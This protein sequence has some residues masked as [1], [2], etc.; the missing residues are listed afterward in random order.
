V[1]PLQLFAGPTSMIRSSFFFGDIVSGPLVPIFG[2]AIVDVDLKRLRGRQSWSFTHRRYWQVDKDLKQI[3]AL[4]AAVNLI[5]KPV[6]TP[7][8]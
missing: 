7:A 4:R 8:G 5:D 6:I 2:P 3:V 1:R